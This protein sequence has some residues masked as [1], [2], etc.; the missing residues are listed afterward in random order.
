MSQKDYDV[1][2]L[3]QENG[4]FELTFKIIIIGD[5]GVGKSCLAIRALKNIFESLYQPTI[6]FEFMSSYIKIDGKI[7]KLQIWDTCGQEVYRSLIS[8]F[9]NNA[10]LAIMVYSIN[11]ENSFNNL[12]FWL[13]EIRTKA[14][15]DINIILIGNKNDLENERKI[16]K[17][18]G[19]EF[20]DNNGLNLF[21]ESSAKTGFNVKQLF[22]EA[23]KILY[24]QHIR[25]T[26]RFSTNSDSFEKDININSKMQSLSIEKDEPNQKRK[27]GCC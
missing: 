24:E 13:N 3:D 27:R 21:F 4:K 16:P 22:I 11:N 23:S 17:D 12:D 9:Y 25:Y 6:G 2:I 20:S 14:N 19:Q 26:N 10:S 18:L 5:S 1:E 8:S 7:I 15:P